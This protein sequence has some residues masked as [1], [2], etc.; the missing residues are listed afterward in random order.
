MYISTSLKLKGNLRRL[1]VRQWSQPR[2]NPVAFKTLR[3][4]FPFVS[5]VYTKLLA[6]LILPL[7]TFDI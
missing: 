6:V 4:P 5:S 1:Q 2:N 3:Y 7:R